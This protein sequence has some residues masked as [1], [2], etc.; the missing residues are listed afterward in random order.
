[1]T[2]CATALRGNRAGSCSAQRLLL[3]LLWGLLLN[4]GRLRRSARRIA[5]VD[6]RR[7]FF[8]RRRRKRRLRRIHGHSAGGW[9]LSLPALL[10]RL[11]RRLLL[12]NDVGN[13]ADSECQ[14]KN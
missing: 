7:L 6:G 2:L 5:F 1:M 9:L 3:L 12:G 8:R 11:P 14:R 4:G 13:T 10:L